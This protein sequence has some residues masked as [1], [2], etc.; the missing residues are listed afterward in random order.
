MDFFGALQNVTLFHQKLN[1]LQAGVDAN[2]A[3]LERLKDQLETIIA[4]F[5]IPD[6]MPIDAGE[7][8]STPST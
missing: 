3:L 6:P 5:R 1:E 8:A 4:F 2:R 7:A